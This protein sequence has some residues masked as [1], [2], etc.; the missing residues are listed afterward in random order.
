MFTIKPLVLAIRTVNNELVRAFVTNRKA[1]Q[2]AVAEAF[3][4]PEE[5]TAAIDEIRRKS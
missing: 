5:R 4:T 2:R 1:I 3:D